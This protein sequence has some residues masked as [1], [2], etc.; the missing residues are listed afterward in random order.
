MYL[1][2]P[3]VNLLWPTYSQTLNL[4]EVQKMRALGSYPYGKCARVMNMSIFL[5]DMP[6]EKIDF[7][8]KCS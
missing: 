5:Q 1:C 7:K 6:I 3:P 8:E 2:I 4:G